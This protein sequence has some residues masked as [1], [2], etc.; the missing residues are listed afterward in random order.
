MSD[1]TRQKL[2]VDLESLFPG[3]TVEVGTQS[4]VIKP[5]GL[6]QIS[7]ISKRLTGVTKLLEK[8][9]VTFDNWNNPESMLK[10]AGV[11]F[12]NFPDVLEEAANLDISDIKRMPIGLIAQIVDKVIEVNLESKELLLKNFG[13]LIKR[14]FPQ[15]EN[16]LEKTPTPTPLKKI[17]G[18]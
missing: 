9:G 11:L 7:E 10:I 3:G 6:E 16:E 13:S 1:K 4:L 5:L 12:D 2:T 14:L 18:K 17:P 15:K 8:V